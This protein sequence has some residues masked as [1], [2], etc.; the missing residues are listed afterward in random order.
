M[1]RFPRR[2]R[3]LGPP[4]AG[5]RCE[6]P[7][8]HESPAVGPAA[9]VVT[10]AGGELHGAVDLDMCHAYCYIIYFNWFYNDLYLLNGGKL[11]EIDHII[12]FGKI[13]CTEP[14]WIIR[15][16]NI[17]GRSERGPNNWRQKQ[18]KEQST[19]FFVKNRT[20]RTFT[21]SRATCPPPRSV[22]ACAR[23]CC[24][25]SKARDRCSEF[26]GMVAPWFPLKGTKKWKKTPGSST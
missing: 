7:R 18:S 4:P 3:R 12:N 20:S 1:G 25:I 6:G 8:C 5:P 13:G 2:L 10:D 15:Q 9:A 14:W 22:S 11:A 17:N 21:W 26:G 23:A 24:E 19:M 16:T